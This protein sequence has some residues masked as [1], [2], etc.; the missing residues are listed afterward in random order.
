MPNTILKNPIL[1]KNTLQGV[2]QFLQEQTLATA[3]ILYGSVARGEADEYSDIDI[4][5]F[6]ASSDDHESR[7]SL[8]EKLEKAF[9]V[10]FDVVSFTGC[11]NNPL[12]VGH[13]ITDGKVLFDNANNWKLLVS[14]REQI[15]EKYNK[16]VADLEREYLVAI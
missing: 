16:Y 13:L 15:L 9:N 3:A 14:Q 10:R 11:K 7:Y 12:F 5:L 2:S 4:C 6:Y 8:E 1:T